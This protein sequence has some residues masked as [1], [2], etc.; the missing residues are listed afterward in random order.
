MVKLENPGLQISTQIPKSFKH[1]LFL[2]PA[3]KVNLAGDAS[4]TFSFFTFPYKWSFSEAMKW[5]GLIVQKHR[6]KSLSAGVPDWVGWRHLWGW[7]NPGSF[8]L[9]A[10]PSVFL[11]K[12]LSHPLWMS[13]PLLLLCSVGCLGESLLNW[14]ITCQGPGIRL[15][16]CIFQDEQVQMSELFTLL[17]T[18]QDDR[19]F[20]PS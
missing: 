2:F 10:G 11:T 12:P 1:I 15:R 8:S 3:Y 5:E 9:A 17:P 6:V 4:V 18:S 7:P 13:H 20:P 19:I 14:N 16:A